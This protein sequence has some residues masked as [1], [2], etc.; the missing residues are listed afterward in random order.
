MSFEAIIRQNPIEISVEESPILIETNGLMF[1]ME[2]AASYP[3]LT[4]NAGK[5]LAVNGNETGV[6]WTTAVTQTYVDTQDSLLQDQID[7]KADATSV[8]QSLAPTLLKSKV[9]QA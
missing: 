3:D 7:L 2:P 4:G 9:G 1:A 5:V 8:S 6:E